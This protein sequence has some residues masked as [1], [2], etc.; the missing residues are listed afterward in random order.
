[1][2]QREELFLSATSEEDVQRQ[3]QIAIDILEEL[4][5]EEGDKL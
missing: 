3:N 4:Q 1:M 5:A 2:G